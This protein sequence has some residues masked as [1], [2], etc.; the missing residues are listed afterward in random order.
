MTRALAGLA[1]AAATG[2]AASLASAPVQQPPVFPVG[3]KRLSLSYASGR[4][5]PGAA[6]DDDPGPVILRRLGMRVTF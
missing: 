3:R 4:F 6:S 5:E 2:I 1:V